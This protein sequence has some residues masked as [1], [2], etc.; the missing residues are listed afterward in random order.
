MLRAWRHDVG[1]KRTAITLHGPQNQSFLVEPGRIV[2]V[3][4]ELDVA[5]LMFYYAVANLQAL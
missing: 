4:E 2:R 1:L 5:V 3:N